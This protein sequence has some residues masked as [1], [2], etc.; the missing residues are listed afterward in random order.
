MP[1]RVRICCQPDAKTYLY[2]SKRAK[3]IGVSVE[4]YAADWL[5]SFFSPNGVSATRPKAS[6]T[7]NIPSKTSRTR[8]NA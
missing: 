8:R 6:N 3:R 1:K 4:D 7:P 2:L 5:V